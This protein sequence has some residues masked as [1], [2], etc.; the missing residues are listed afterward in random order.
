MKKKIITAILQPDAKPISLVIEEQKKRAEDERKL[1]ETKM[2][3][4]EEEQKCAKTKKPIPS[5]TERFDSMTFEDAMHNL[6]YVKRS[7]RNKRDVENVLAKNLDL[8]KNEVFTYPDV[9]KIR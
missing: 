5:E 7:N 3:N 2:K 6:I 8:G 1:Y 4:K 9:I